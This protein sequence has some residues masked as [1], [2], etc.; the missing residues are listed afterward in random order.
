MER[1]ISILGSLS[2]SLLAVATGVGTALTVGGVFGAFSV[3][4][5]QRGSVVK[6]M[7]EAA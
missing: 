4:P 7:R 2:R 5:A 1:L 6:A 3:L